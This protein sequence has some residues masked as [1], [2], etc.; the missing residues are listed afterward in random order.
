MSWAR[1]IVGSVLLLPGVVCAQEAAAPIYQRMRSGAEDWQA[2]GGGSWRGLGAIGGAY[3]AGYG[4]YF[5]PFFPPPFVAGTWY[6]RPYPYHFDYYQSRW[7]MGRG[8]MGAEMMPISE[9]PCLSEPPPAAESPSA[10]E[11]T[12][13]A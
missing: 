9:C 5:N 13:G 12:P 4:G 3:G 7:G 10:N 8:P 2:R 6:E 1:L 11:S